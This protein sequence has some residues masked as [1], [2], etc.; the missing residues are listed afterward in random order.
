MFLRTH[1]K[2]GGDIMATIMVD[3]SENTPNKNPTKTKDK[4]KATLNGAKG[5]F[6]SAS[7]II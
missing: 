4:S 5:I 2:K 6:G 3:D 7:E 1:R